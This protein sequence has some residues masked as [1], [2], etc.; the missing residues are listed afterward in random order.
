MTDTWENLYPS[1]E[2]NLVV[3]NR[4][5]IF[6]GFTFQTWNLQKRLDRI[7]YYSEVI[8]SKTMSIIG[9][10]PINGQY[11]SDHASVICE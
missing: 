8:S 2:G 3:G 10:E 1:K 9:I 11:L 4:S 6:Q 5:D 7:F